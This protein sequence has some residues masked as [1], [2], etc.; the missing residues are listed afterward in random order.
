MSLRVTK[1]LQALGLLLI[2]FF[3]TKVQAPKYHGFFFGFGTKSS[4]RQSYFEPNTHDVGCRCCAA[5]EV[6]LRLDRVLRASSVPRLLELTRKPNKG[7][8]KTT[9]P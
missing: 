9:V 2:G 8:T 6:G 7:L 5:K 3:L 1:V 4:F